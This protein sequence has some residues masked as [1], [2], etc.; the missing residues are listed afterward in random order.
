[1]QQFDEL[2]GTRERMITARRQVRALAPIRD[3][4][5]AIDGA[6][7]RLR[8]IE[9]VGSFTDPASPRRC[10]GTNATDLLRAAE[11][12]LTGRR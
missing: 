2:S 1:M 9:A 5:R 11:Q 3:H 4:R 10:G 8:V 6:V 7:A 12:D